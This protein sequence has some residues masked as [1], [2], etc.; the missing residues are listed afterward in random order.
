MPLSLFSRLFPLALLVLLLACNSRPDG[1]IVPSWTSEIL[2]PLIK[3][4]VTGEEILQI[5]D[6]SAFSYS[7]VYDFG[8]GAGQE[9]IVV[10]EGSL[11][12]L[13]KDE[14]LNTSFTKLELDSGVMVFTISNSMD[15]DIRQGTVFT[16]YQHG[17]VL[18]SYT[19][20]QDLAAHSGFLT[21]AELS[22][23]GKTLY[24]DVTI[25]ITNAA[26]HGSGGQPIP[27]NADKKLVVNVT[28]KNTNIKSIT[29]KP[30]S[31]EMADT[32]A[33]NLNGR[34]VNTSAVSGNI[35]TYA[36]N[37]FPFNIAM[38][39]YF[40]DDLYVRQDSMFSAS[41]L[42]PVAT[43]PE[44][45]VKLT[46]TYDINRSGHVNSAKYV[47]S[48]VRF[49]SNTEFTITKD[50]FLDLQIVGDLKLNVNN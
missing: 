3:T 33:F 42:I 7:K 32:A 10:P 16:V 24:P 50:N 6:L 20:P 21:S 15:I 40:M 1:K 4:R 44:E 47:N 5:Q 35:I 22:L 39:F 45:E 8:L 23:A 29:L 14:N 34:A 26:T 48:S 38:Q 9:N 28:V 17:E 30:G 11:P 49:F 19:L 18:L 27:V 25:K 12:S 46:E 13:S 43:S 2:G 31:Y 41:R 36:K 37:R